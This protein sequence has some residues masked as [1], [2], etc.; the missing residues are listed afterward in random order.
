MAEG[1]GNAPTSDDADPVFETGAASLYLPAFRKVVAARVGFAP[2]SSGLTVRC[3]TNYHHLA[4]LN[5]ELRFVNAEWADEREGFTGP[6][7]SIRA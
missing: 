7:Q 5:L 6:H 4:L 2:T 1:V 3:V